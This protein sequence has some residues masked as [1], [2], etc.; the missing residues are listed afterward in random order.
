LYVKYSRIRTYLYF[1]DNNT[2][3]KDYP[4][5]ECAK[6]MRSIEEEAWKW[7]LPHM[8]GREA[9]SE[10]LLDVIGVIAFVGRDDKDG[11]S[12]ARS[13]C[14]AWQTLISDRSMAVQTSIETI[15]EFLGHKRI[16]MVGVSR[17]PASFSASLYKELCGR[18]YDVVP[19]NPGVETIEG[20]RC[21]RRVQEIEP[22]V[23]A[24]LLM[25]SPEVTDTVVR[26]CAEAGVQSVWMYRAAGKGAVSYTAVQ[27]CEEH[28]IRVVPGQCPFMFLPEAGGVHRFHGWVRKIT[29]RYPRHSAA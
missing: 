19:V 26:D 7:R 5:L 18:G 15:E 23:E 11:A 20:K 2:F 13:S 14:G 4:A 8:R 12:L 17:D 3:I 24:A 9:D 16:A 1:I 25:T 21:F 28:G 6:N 29:G 27:F 22:P 10:S